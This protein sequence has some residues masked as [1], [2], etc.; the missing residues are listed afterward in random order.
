M[1]IKVKIMVFLVFVIRAHSQ[2]HRL[3]SP[4]VCCVLLMH[5]LIFMSRLKWQ[6]IFDTSICIAQHK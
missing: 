5:V 1:L 2:C 4:G 3:W 6:Q